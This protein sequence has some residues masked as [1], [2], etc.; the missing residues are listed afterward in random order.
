[1]WK[2]DI[3]PSELPDFYGEM[4]FHSYQQI[5]YRDELDQLHT[6]FNVAGLHPDLGL[7]FIIQHQTGASLFS[8][9]PRDTDHSH[10]DK[11]VVDEFDVLIDATLNSS[12]NQSLAWSE[13]KREQLAARYKE[14]EE[15][16]R[17]AAAVVAMKTQS[18]GLVRPVIRV[19]SLM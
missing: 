16:S 6:F 7:V 11:C 15:A 3:T 5:E 8:F 4:T 1:M 17:N 10:L 13:E 18:A 12:L 19:S 2:S 9:Y 14:L